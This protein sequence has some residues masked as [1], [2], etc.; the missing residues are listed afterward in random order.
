MR[1]IVP[2]T[3]HAN[4]AECGTVAIWQNARTSD[5]VFAAGTRFIA[6]IG[7]TD[8][9]FIDLLEHRPMRRPPWCSIGFP[10]I[11]HFRS[12][13]ATWPGIVVRL[14]LRAIADD[15]VPNAGQLASR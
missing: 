10:D 7:R 9:V 1:T 6:A 4:A 14:A 13:P 15:R 8:T 5:A 12:S 3:Y 2:L 11:R